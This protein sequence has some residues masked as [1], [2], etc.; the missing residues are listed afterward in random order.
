M[1]TTII[2]ITVQ[3]LEVISAGAPLYDEVHLK[4]VKISE[5]VGDV[6]VELGRCASLQRLSDERAS[7]RAGGRA[8]FTL[9][10]KK[11]KRS[12]DPSKIDEIQT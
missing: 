2:S 10:A 7:G 5:Y 9:F 8:F 11:N 1:R 4:G 3:S 12:R 6:E